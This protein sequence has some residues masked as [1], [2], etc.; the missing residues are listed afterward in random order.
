MGIKDFKSKWGTCSTRGDIS[1]N[2]RVVIAPHRIVDYVVVHE[3][4]HLTHLDHSSIFWRQVAHL[5]PD[6]KECR[7]WLKVNG[8]SLVV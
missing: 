5:I 7:E 6:Y 1:Y 2:W 4:A 8:V 3:L